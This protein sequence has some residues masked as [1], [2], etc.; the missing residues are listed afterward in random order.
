MTVNN[1][2][3]T[4]NYRVIL[5]LE[6]I[7]LFTKVIYLGKLP[8]YFISYAPGVCEIVPD[9]FAQLLFSR[10]SQNC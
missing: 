7:G 6:I 2:S 5:T 4:V 10:K 8:Q 3:M 9:I 1:C